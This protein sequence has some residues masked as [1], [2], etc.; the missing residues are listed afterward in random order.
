MMALF[1]RCWLQARPHL[2]KVSL[3]LSMFALGFSLSIII[4]QS[5]FDR[6]YANAI[7]LEKLTEQCI[8][9]WKD[10]NNTI[11]RLRASR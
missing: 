8:A 2:P 6:A 1:Y 9:G 3:A 4:R 10:A 5:S 7:R 11:Q